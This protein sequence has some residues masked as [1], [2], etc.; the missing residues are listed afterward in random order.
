MYHAQNF[1]DAVH[2]AEKLVEMGGIGHTSCLYTDQDNC[3]EH[4]AYFGDKMKT[5]RILI[6]TPA[7]QGGIGDLYNFKLAPSLTLGCGSWGGNSI[8]ENVGPKHLINT[9]TVAK[10]A[11]NMLWHKL[12]KSIYFRRGCLPIALEEIA[13]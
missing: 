13:N 5:S 7:S 8:S 12:P 6:N 3:P 11:E 10:R 1:E 4:V 2:K 9:K